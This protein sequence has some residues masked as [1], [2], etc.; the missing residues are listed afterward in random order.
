MLLFNDRKNAK[1]YIEYARQHGALSVTENRQ[2]L[3]SGVSLVIF[4]DEGM[5]G[6]VLNNASS[7]LEG[8]K[9]N[10]DILEVADLFEG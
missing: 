8:K 10:P 1:A 6:I 5:P 3:E 2:N 4:N 9:W 7:I